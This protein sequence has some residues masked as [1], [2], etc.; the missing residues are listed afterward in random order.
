MLQI[1]N[2]ASDD[3]S[4]LKK[5]KKRNAQE[6]DL[7]VSDDDE[8]SHVSISLCASDGSSDHNAKEC[9]GIDEPATPDNRK[10]RLD[11][12]I[13]KT[14]TPD[15][16]DE[17]MSEMDQIRD[18]K[19]DPTYDWRQEFETPRNSKETSSLLQ[20]INKT[21]KYLEV[22]QKLKLVTERITAETTKPR[23]KIQNFHGILKDFQINATNVGASIEAS[24]Q[25]P[26]GILL[27]DEMG[28]GKTVT[29]IAIIQIKMMEN[30]GLKAV[31]LA[32][33][34]LTAVWK[35]EFKKFC[36]YEP[37]EVVTWDKVCLISF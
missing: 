2:P 29:A 13:A 34:G 37:N 23:P 16:D 24:N 5:R 22:K 12:E 21:I 9:S 7:S 19:E 30:P 3:P 11:A 10:E 15:P 14:K 26:V 17:K 36:S 33:C 20:A 35:K 6:I 1:A 25:D 4:P 18:F 32:P 27:C 31:V 28:L 8:A